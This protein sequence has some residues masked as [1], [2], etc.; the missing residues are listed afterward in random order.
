MTRAAPRIPRSVP[1]GKRKPND[2]LRPRHTAF[3][4]SLG[5]CVACGAQGPI[6]AA[7]VRMSRAG[8]EGK[9]GGMGYKPDARWLVP[10]CPSCHRIDQHTKEG[11]PAFW[12]RLGI[13]PVDLSLRLWTVTGD[14]QQGLRAVM[15]A[16]Q[17][18]ALHR[19]P[20]RGGRD[21][22]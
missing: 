5:M 19:N 8:L 22:A 3:I 14:L 7:H 17:A 1:Q 2:R 6:D 10:L 13:D 20:P 12:A 4:H 18:I 11:E 15:R 9:Y 16:R 21:P